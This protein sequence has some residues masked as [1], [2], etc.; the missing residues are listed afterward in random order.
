MNKELISKENAVDIIQQFYNKAEDVPL[1][2]LLS[3]VRCALLSA[4][5]A[6]IDY[7]FDSDYTLACLKRAEQK[8]YDSAGVPIK[9]TSRHGCWIK[10]DNHRWKCSICGK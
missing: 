5:P 9:I 6:P 7:K 1:K 4:P 8:V 10:I 2:F 3:E